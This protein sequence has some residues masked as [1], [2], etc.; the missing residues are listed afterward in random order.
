MIEHLARYRLPILLALCLGTAIA[1][2]FFRADYGPESVAFMYPLTAVIA[3]VIV[4]GL[5]RL[6]RPVLEIQAGDHD[7]D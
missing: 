2:W 1:G 4:V 3:V 7:A 5:T 6:L